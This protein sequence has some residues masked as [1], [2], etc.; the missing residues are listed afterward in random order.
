MAP[1]R[2]HGP[3]G[4]GENQCKSRAFGWIKAQAPT[5]KVAGKVL[6]N[7]FHFSGIMAVTFLTVNSRN[8]WIICLKRMLKVASIIIAS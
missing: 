6:K 4:G 3:V 1:V 8:Y 5:N 2:V 7:I